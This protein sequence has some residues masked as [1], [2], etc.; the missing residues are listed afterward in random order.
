MRFI[1][2]RHEKYRKQ[3][4]F[5]PIHEQEISRAVLCR[6]GLNI[7]NISFLYVYFRDGSYLEYRKDTILGWDSLLGKKTLVG[8]CTHARTSSPPAV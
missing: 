7:K 2:E 4:L 1:T 3:K 6:H 5:P 8:T